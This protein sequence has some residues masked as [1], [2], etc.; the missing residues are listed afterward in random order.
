MSLGPS[1]TYNIT[2][3]LYDIYTDGGDVPCST[4]CL[5]TVIQRLNT[6]ET[7]TAEKW[8]LYTN[9]TQWQIQLV[10]CCLFHAVSGSR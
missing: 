8:I 10:T 5:F 3:L 2:N 9:K 7:F 4:G 6:D 1:L